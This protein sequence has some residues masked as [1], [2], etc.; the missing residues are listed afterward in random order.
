MIGF[1]VTLVLLVL[2]TVLY[3]LIT[4]MKIVGGNEL[5]IVSGTVR[6]RGFK[7]LSGGRAFIIPLFNRFAKIDLTPYTI[8][9]VV[10]SAIADGV[11][12][13][14][15][16][17]TV[18]FA[19]SSSASG[20]ERAATR[21]LELTQNQEHLKAIASSIIEGHL[22]DSIASM[23][24]EAVMRDKDT[25]VSKMINVCKSDLENIGLEITT[26][27]IA[28]VDD[29]RLDGV[30]EP[31]LYI[32]LLKRVQAANA[33]TQARTA[34]ANAKAAAVEKEQERRA[35]VEV[36]NLENQLENLRA[37]TE[38]KIDQVGQQKAVGVEQAIRNASAELAGIES[39][40][41]SETERI[42]MLKKEY[43]ANIITRAMAVKEKK[44]LE[45]Q[46][47]AA[48]I[49][50]KAQG[51]IDQ[52]KQTL[53]ILDDKDDNS[54]RLTYIIENFE[55]II[56]PLAE[57]L[58]LYPAEKMTVITG[59]QGAGTGPISAIHPNA[60]DAGKNDM[61]KQV[62]SAS[63]GRQVATVNHEKQEG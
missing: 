36:R 35:E 40:I 8:E 24:P 51:E 5:G 16:T 54:G 32:A 41:A 3:Q 33:Q 48:M 49:K 55:R 18:S 39:K 50:G 29:H 25:L 61:L 37:D 13:L 2:I 47:R 7:T 27:N 9:V 14:N 59:V 52:L 26:M 4:K 20:R 62:L 38:L 60:V 44:I 57:T 53:E 42:N 45:A 19:I 17:A 43:E 10:D 58:Q 34:E 23:T 11:V 63:L 6:K 12:P 56:T 31:D 46:S 15:V 1:T 22:R 28:D 30:E 21:I